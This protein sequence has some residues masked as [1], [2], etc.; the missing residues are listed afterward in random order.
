MTMWS[1]PT[2][3]EKQHNSGKHFVFAQGGDHITTKRDG[4]SLIGVPRQNLKEHLRNNH[5]EANQEVKWGECPMVYH[6][7]HVPLVH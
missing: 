7:I 6:T 2:F 1:S 3:M 4:G 5:D